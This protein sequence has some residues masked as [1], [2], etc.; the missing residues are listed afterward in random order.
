M[1]MARKIGCNAPAIIVG[2][3]SIGYDE[4]MLRQALYQTCLTSAPMGQTELH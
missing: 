1:Q 2:Y 3:N 4:G